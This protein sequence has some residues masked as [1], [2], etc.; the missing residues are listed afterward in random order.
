MRP[1]QAISKFKIYQENTSIQNYWANYA[2]ENVLLKTHPR[3]K[4]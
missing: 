2:D 3:V 1:T 4:Q